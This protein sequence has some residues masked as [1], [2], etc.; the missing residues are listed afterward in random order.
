MPDSGGGGASGSWEVTHLLDLI[1]IKDAPF[2]ELERFEAIPSDGSSSSSSSSDGDGE[3]GSV[4]L[5]IPSPLPILIQRPA[6][7]E[8][9]WEHQTAAIDEQKAYLLHVK[10]ILARKEDELPTESSESLIGTLI[11]TLL[12]ELAEEFAVF[13]IKKLLT[14]LAGLGGGA[15]GVIAFLS[16][17]GFLW[18]KDLWDHYVLGQQICEQG[19]AELDAI[20]NLDISTEE[21]DVPKAWDYFR[22]RETII[23]RQQQHIH[24]LLTEIIALEQQTKDA[25]GLPG[26]D[27]TELI[28]AIQEL[29]MAGYEIEAEDFKIRKLGR[30]L[31]TGS[32]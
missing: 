10:D 7:P 17:I 1:H 2:Y 14:W 9:A 28:A 16:V 26:S 15:S 31:T 3:S 21:G 8:T 18:L 25:I 5:E 11:S 6:F 19:I 20:R 27:N 24:N 4:T 32:W 29:G 12:G 30:T 22:L 13:G 23:A